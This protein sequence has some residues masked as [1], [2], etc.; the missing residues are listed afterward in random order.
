MYS[1]VEGPL[2]EQR[3]GAGCGDMSGGRGGLSHGHA[4]VVVHDTKLPSDAECM[5]RRSVE[6]E[7]SS[8]RKWE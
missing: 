5:Q 4:A 2:V 7:S 8:G 6:L 3:A 1:R